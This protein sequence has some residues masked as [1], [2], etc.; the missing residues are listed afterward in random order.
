MFEIIVIIAFL[1][2][3]AV[4]IRA[5][6]IGFSRRTSRRLR[7]IYF[8]YVAVI[9][10]VAYY[11]TFHFNYYANANT[12]MFGWPIPMYAFQRHDASSPWL[13]FVGPPVFIA[14]PLNLLLFIFLPS[15][16]ILFIARRSRLA[17]SLALEK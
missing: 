9:V 12:R 7:M 2:M 15:L 13:D 5:A 1:L 16:V 14:Y 17:A 8:G 11:T 4:V 6:V 10:P 3:V